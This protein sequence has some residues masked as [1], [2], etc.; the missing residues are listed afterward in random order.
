VGSSDP[1]V[2]DDANVIFLHALIETQ[3]R[4]AFAQVVKAKAGIF[5]DPRF[6]FV[7]L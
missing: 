4:Q 6:R 1:A 5:I 3:M 2:T 7:S